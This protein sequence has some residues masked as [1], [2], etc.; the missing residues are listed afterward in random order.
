MYA[1]L[2]KK[3]FME[4]T[5]LYVSVFIFTASSFPM[6]K[7]ESFEDEFPCSM[8]SFLEDDFL[9]GNFFQDNNDLNQPLWTQNS[10]TQFTNS[11]SSP[12]LLLTLLDSIDEQN[13]AQPSQTIEKTSIQNPQP[14][15]KRKTKNNKKAPFR[16]YCGR[17]YFKNTK[18]KKPRNHNPCTQEGC[19]R[20]LL[21]KNGLEAHLIYDHD[22]CIFCRICNTRFSMS[23][24]IYELHLK[25]CLNYK[26]KRD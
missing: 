9:Q 24:P 3:N 19:N 12:A 7:S 18:I 23:N 25:Y 15:Y 21:S 13:C 17:M 14:K 1:S 10:V 16:K 6:E 26:I 5:F 4:I 11:I 8:M 22:M 2:L 20:I